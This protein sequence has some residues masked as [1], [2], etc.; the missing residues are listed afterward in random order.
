MLEE[1]Y[2]CRKEE[3]DNCIKEAEAKIEEKL[4]KIDY[5]KNKE[6]LDKTEENYSIK[7]SVICKAVYIKGLKDGINLINECRI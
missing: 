6:I 2:C 1:L 5:E 7:M 4:F 3:I